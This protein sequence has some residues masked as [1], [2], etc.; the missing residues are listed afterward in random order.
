MRKIP[1]RNPRIKKTQKER[2]IVLKEESLYKPLM[3]TFLVFLFL[4]TILFNNSIFDSLY[5]SQMIF[6][7]RAFGILSLSLGTTL[8]GLPTIDAF[9]ITSVV[10]QTFINLIF[11]TGFIIVSD[12]F[13][14]FLGYR[15]TNTLSKI[16]QK[17]KNGIKQKPYDHRIKKYGNLGVLIFASSPLPFTI[18][19]YY[20]GAVKLNLQRFILAVGVG[21]TIKYGVFILFFRLFNI[22]INDV[23]SSLLSW[24]SNW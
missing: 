24:I 23:W 17:K 12:T 16:Y 2:N 5:P 13:G 9:F 10:N 14:A 6:F 22:N 3:T 7:R 18:A 4:F 11:L 8:F 19:V 15:F 1:K 21:R 20:A